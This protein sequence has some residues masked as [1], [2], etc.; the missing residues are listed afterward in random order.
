MT[1]EE[2]EDAWERASPWFE[3]AL[4][5]GGNLWTLDAVKAEIL[6]GRAQFWSND[7]ASAVTQFV[8]SPSAK[9][10]SYWLLGGDTQGLRD[11]LPQAERWGIENDCLVF[12]GTGRRGFERRFGSAGYKARA[13]VYVKDLRPMVGAMIQ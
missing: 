13:T 7:T 9:T 10:L 6:A 4:R 2:F 11:L 3:I 5:H 12:T 8:Y 1:P